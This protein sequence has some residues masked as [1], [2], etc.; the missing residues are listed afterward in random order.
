MNR[1]HENLKII[2]QSKGYDFMLIFILSGCIENR[3][4]L[5]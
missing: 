5:P 2:I 4:A 1:A 3:E